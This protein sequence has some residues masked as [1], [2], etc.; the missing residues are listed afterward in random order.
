[1][2]AK[3][4]GQLKRTRLLLGLFSLVVLAGCGLIPTT[5]ATLSPGGTASASN[6]APNESI[7]FLLEN[8]SGPVTIWAQ[9]TNPAGAQLELTVLN[10]DQVPLVKSVAHTWFGLPDLVYASQ[11]TKPLIVVTPTTGPRL[12]LDAFPG[13]TYYLQVTNLSGVPVDIQVGATTLTPNPSGSNNDTIAPGASVSGAIELLGE[14]DSYLVGTGY[15]YL[16]ASGAGAAFL[17][18]DVYSA[19]TAGAPKQQTLSVGDT[20]CVPVTNGQFV[21]VHTRGN[22]PAYAGFDEDGSLRYTLTL[23]QDQT[24][25][26]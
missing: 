7:Y 19:Q 16:Q 4:V 24:S 20:N 1:M 25:C 13:A 2:G 3:E 21:L 22:P 18:A 8:A 15:L 10:R 6:L 9:A 26:P 23:Y 14:Q 17:V 12:N 5:E 11:G